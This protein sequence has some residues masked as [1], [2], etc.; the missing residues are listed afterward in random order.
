MRLFQN[1]GLYPSY[2]PRLNQLAANATRFEARRDV[3]L[4]D[5]FGAPHFL[6]PVL[7]GS[8]DAF[9]TNG[10][11]EVLQRQW[12]RA[13]GMSGTP[14]SEAILLA[15]I[16]HHRTEVFY[17]LDPVRYPSA[18]VARL[19]A[20]VKTTLAWRAAPS[21]NADLTAYGA[22]LGNFP[23]ILESWRSKGCRAELFFP[24][25]DPVMDEY[26]QGERPI[27]VAFVGGYSRHHSARGR[28]LEQVADLSAR[29]KIVFC[30]D[31]S[32]LT[33]LAESAI[34]RLLPL[35]K[36]RRPDAIARI[37]RPPVFGRDLYALFGSAKIVLNG[38]IDMAGH[39]RGNMRCFESMGCGALLVSDA[40]NYPEGMRDGETI[41]TYQNGN[42][43]QV[44]VENCLC[45]WDELK[46]RAEKGR[47][48]VRDLYSKERQWA[49]FEQLLGR[50]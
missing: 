41:A 43:C 19:P 21:G 1:S 6:K 23:S 39:D 44:Q 18:F 37:A 22:V 5:R 11:D 7:E 17:N 33:R 47:A 36:H 12:A 4:H 42:D 30:L 27:D 24:A 28:T 38:A 3:F 26:G 25:V 13:Q 46:A 45:G 14:T 20:C 48:A 29:H 50:L 49:L 8:P 10:D 34:G 16:E 40:G 32:R 2:L 31:A 9:F 15:Q 35:G